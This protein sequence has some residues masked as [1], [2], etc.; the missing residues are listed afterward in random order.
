VIRLVL[1]DVDGT[2]ITTGGAGVKAF[3]RTAV[4]EFQL[5]KVTEHLRF[6]GRTDTSI[7]RDFFCRYDLEPSPDNFRRFMDCYVFWLDYL[8]DKLEG[9]TLSGVWKLVREFQALPQPP[10]LGLLT[11]NIRLGAEIKLRFY[12]LWDNFTTGAF[13]D[14]HEDRNRL[15]SIAHQRAQ[16]IGRRDL[17]GEEILVIGDTPLDIA[18]AKSIKAKTLAVASGGHSLDELREH[19]PTWAVPDLQKVNIAELCAD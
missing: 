5:E 16:R 12:H 3:E 11:G 13:G 4:S 15:A 17:L 8:M 1:F 7:I 18:C 19:E 14:D 6:A 9:G 2:L 10:V